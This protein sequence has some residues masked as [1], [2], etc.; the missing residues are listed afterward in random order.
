MTAWLLYCLVPYSVHSLLYHRPLEPFK[1]NLLWGTSHVQLFAFV[2]CI[3]KPR[4][5]QESENFMKWL[6]VVSGKKSLWTAQLNA[7]SQAPCKHRRANVT[8]TRARFVCRLMSQVNGRWLWL[9]SLVVQNYFMLIIIAAVVKVLGIPL[10]LREFLSVCLYA[11][12]FSYE[13]EIFLNKMFTR[14]SDILCAQPY[15]RLSHSGAVNSLQYWHAFNLSGTTELHGLVFSEHWCLVSTFRRNYDA[16]YC[17]CFTGVLS[18]H[19]SH[20]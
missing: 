8:F 9:C 20:A 5:L 14:F 6:A 4:Y 17:A 10:K 1:S 18:Y 7:L 12:S 2:S 13:N 3:S 15:W 11:A 19:L 16:H